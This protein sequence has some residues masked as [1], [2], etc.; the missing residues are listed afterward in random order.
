MTNCNM[1]KKPLGEESDK[2]VHGICKAEYLDRVNNGM[3]GDCG[4]NPVLSDSK[5]WCQA[6]GNED[7]FK[8][9]TG[10]Q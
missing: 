9:F 6:C 7:E 5:S 2:K 4:E 3:C 8:N 1:C 10:P